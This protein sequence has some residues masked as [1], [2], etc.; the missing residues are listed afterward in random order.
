V[1][2]VAEGW[3]EAVDAAD[4][5]GTGAAAATTYSYELHTTVRVSADGLNDYLDTLRVKV[6]SG[7]GP[8]PTGVFPIVEWRRPNGTWAALN[9]QS[10]TTTDAVYVYLENVPADVTIQHRLTFDALDVTT[11]QN[12]SGSTR[13]TRNERLVNRAGTNLAFV[14]GTSAIG[15]AQPAVPLIQHDDVIV[16]N[17][18]VGLQQ[19]LANL[20]T[21]LLGSASPTSYWIKL[22]VEFGYEVVSA[23]PPMPSLVS[24]LPIGFLPAS[25]YEATVPSRLYQLI[26]N[27][28]S[29]KPFGPTQGLYSIDVTVFTTLTGDGSTNV[30]I[31]RLR[32]LVYDN[33]PASA[34]SPSVPTGPEDSSG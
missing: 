6:L 22:A 20:F 26:T 31:L 29:D 1:S 9:L 7:A 4:G 25:Q 18:G 33:S 12:A 17:G 16:F 30:P 14:Y 15:F 23:V 2:K 3:A 11:W 13:L 21:A 19:A 32:H 24:F 10:H 27:W 34:A 28:R 5:V 8:S